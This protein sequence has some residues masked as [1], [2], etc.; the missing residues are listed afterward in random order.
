MMRKLKWLSLPIG[1]LFI[2]VLTNCKSVDPLQKSKHDRIQLQ[3]LVESHVKFLNTG[4]AKGLESI[5]ADD[6]EGISPVTKFESKEQL[7]SQLIE[8]Q[9]KQN[10]TIQIEI[11]EIYTSNEMAFVVLDWKA[12]TNAGKPAE[13]LLFTKKHLQIWE[14]GKNN[15]LLK[16]SLFYN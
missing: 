11:I 7:I 6:Y 3:N 12:L 2:F 16:R 14:K 4:N 5:Y 9:Q 1:L 10:I 8:N 13:Q 15:W